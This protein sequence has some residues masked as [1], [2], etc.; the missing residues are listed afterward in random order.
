MRFLKESNQ[1]KMNNIFEIDCKNQKAKSRTEKERNKEERV[2]VFVVF[3]WG[4]GGLEES[5]HD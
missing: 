4:F 2:L 5:I 3:G 1:L